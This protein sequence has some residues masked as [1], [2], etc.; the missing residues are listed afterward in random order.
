VS[1]YFEVADLQRLAADFGRIELFMAGGASKMLIEAGD[2]L[3]DAWKDNAKLTAG[4]HGKWY[5]NSIQCK[6]DG[7]FAVEV[8]PT[9]GRRQGTR[10]FEFGSENQPPHLDGQRALEAE[11]PRFERRVEIYAA[12]IF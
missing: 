8:G 6:S 11:L 10:S 1:V 5:P 12:G 2:D 4:Q 7:P 9:P 3:R